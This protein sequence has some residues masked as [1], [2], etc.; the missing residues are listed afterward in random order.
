MTLVIAKKR[1][2]LLP[3]VDIDAP[4]CVNC[5]ACV[6]VCPVK[7]C[8]NASGDYVEID[9][10]LCIGCGACIDR[11]T[12]G[13]R[14]YVDDME[15]FIHRTVAAGKK[16]VVVVAPSV[17]ANFGEDYKHL[18]GWLTEACGV[19]AVF[20]V[21]FGAEL[22]VKS[23]VEYIKTHHPKCLIAQ[24]CPAIVSYIELYLP[25]L[26]PYLAPIDSPL[27]HTM[28]MVREFFP[29]YADCQIAALTPCLAKKHE[30]MET[31]LGD[32][33]VSFK[34]LKKYFQDN[35][36]DLK[37]FPEVD[38]IN[39]APE[40][41]VLFPKPGG[42]LKT[43]AREMPEAVEKTR[44]IEGEIVYEYLIGLQDAIESGVS[45]MVIDCLNCDHGCNGGP[46]S[47]ACTRT[48]LDQIE[49]KLEKRQ[50][51][52]SEQHQKKQTETQPGV[53]YEKY[54]DG[55]LNLFWK[56]GLYERK[57]RNRSSN[58]HLDVPS[59]L[60]LNK[61]Y[62]RMGKQNTEALFNCNGCGYEGC[63]SMAIAIHN[64][65]NKPENCLHYAKNRAVENREGL[66]RIFSNT[67]A[68]MCI[69]DEQMNILEVNEALCEMFGSAKD[70]FVGTALFKAHF[71][72]Y[73]GGNRSVLEF[74]IKR[75][76][77]SN[78]NCLFTA[79][80]FKQHSPDGLKKGY[81]AMITDA[82]QQA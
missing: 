48:S 19:E 40:R 71:D 54:L 74:R 7:Y 60:E 57:Y 41:A 49:A 16:T 27:G 77:G 21:S 26:I 6:H 10:D 33:N 3:L 52:L 32:F 45:P 56:D 42:L 73:L 2:K 11:C 28:K 20:D 18:N 30:F 36:I 78:L 23:Y 31:H 22:T 34:S 50:K 38:Y 72:A 24:P 70:R 51:E 55:I 46:L 17:V 81:F 63:E 35:K 39:P 58:N 79:S 1:E 68:G 67:T 44:R 5:H 14:F 76:D 53:E 4:K 8:N 47:A 9:H 64:G 66:H 12:H 82:S 59:E 62:Q 69:V 75:P 37:T 13:A 15:A 25:D 29:E 65:L 43:L 61:I 80:E